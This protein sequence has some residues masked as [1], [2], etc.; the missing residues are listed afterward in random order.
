M[1]ARAKASRHGRVARAVLAIVLAVPAVAAAAQAPLWELGLGIGGIGYEDYRGSDTAHAYPLPVPYFVYRGDF[2]KS[3]REGVRGLLLNQRI[4]ELSVSVGATTP[5]RSDQDEARRGMP[6]LKATLEL[7][8][9]LQV[10]LWQSAGRGAR[11]DLRVPV[12][13]VVTV[14][15]EPRAVGWFTTPNLN[16]DLRDVGGL[17]GWDL[18]VLVGPVYAD[19]GYN[20]FYYSVA[21]QFATATRP[22]Y[23]ARGGYSGV[24]AVASL[25]RRW[26]RHWLG[27]YLRHDELGGAV[28]EPSPLVRSHHYWSG[29]VGFAWLVGASS[30]LVE[31][32]DE[33]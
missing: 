6:D 14:E 2:L 23:E 13:R 16:L 19:A 31:A 18:G 21:A 17:A 5:V 22:P 10:R 1:S 20:R 8:P 25:S 24:E 26:S 9:Q 3:D 15:A 7:G 30:R 12:R 11:L 27:A 28:F 4:V 32:G 29:G 33:R